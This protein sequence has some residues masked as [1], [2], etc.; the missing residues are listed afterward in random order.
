[1]NERLYPEWTAFIQVEKRKV[2][3]LVENKQKFE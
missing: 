3:Y 1:M 2:N